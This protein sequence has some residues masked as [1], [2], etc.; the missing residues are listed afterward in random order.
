MHE[1]AQH[2]S[3][4][5]EHKEELQDTAGKPQES[6]EETPKAST[7]QDSSGSSSEDRDGD[8]DFQDFL[9]P[10]AAVGS[11]NRRRSSGHLNFVDLVSA[12][13]GS[14]LAGLEAKQRDN[15]TVYSRSTGT[16]S[17]RWRKCLEM[18]SNK[19]AK[20]PVSKAPTLKDLKDESETV[21]LKR[22][23]DGR[24]T[25]QELGPCVPPTGLEFEHFPGADGRPR[26]SFCSSFESGNLAVAQCEGPDLYTLLVD[27]DANTDGYTQWFYFAVQGGSCGLKVTFRLVNMAKS[28]SLFGEK[29]MRPVVWSE[30]SG[31]GWERGCADVSYSKSAEA[32]A[33]QPLMS[34]QKQ[35]YTL[36]FSYTFEHD[37]D[38]VFFAYHY[39]YTYSHLCDFIDALEAHPYAG[40]L[41]SRRVLCR[42]IGDLPCEVLDVDCDTP[43]APTSDK[44]IAVITARIHPGESNASWMMHG[45]MSFL[46]SPAAEAKALRQAF[47]W[48]IVPMLNPDGVVRGCYR[49]GLA[50]TDLN[51]V[52]AKPSKILHPEIYHLKETIKRAGRTVELYI[53]F[54]GHSK[55]E[56]IFFYGGKA[57]DRDRNADI[58]LL[59]RLCC[60]GSSDFKWRKCA[61]NLNESKM[62]TARLVGFRE[63]GIQRV[64]TVEASFAGSG[65]AV[66]E[67]EAEASASEASEASDAVGEQEGQEE[68]SAL[69]EHQE[70]IKEAATVLLQQ[71]AT[72]ERRESV[73]GGTAIRK[74]TRSDLAQVQQS[75]RRRSLRQMTSRSGSEEDLKSPKE[76]SPANPRPSHLRQPSCPVSPN[77]PTS[78]RMSGASSP[79]AA[80]SASAELTAKSKEKVKQN[81]RRASEM[82]GENPESI[83]NE[84]NPKRLELAGP[85]IGRAICA[86]WQ[87]EVPAAN[88]QP[89]DGFLDGTESKQWPHLHYHRLTAEAAQRELSKLLSGRVGH[90]KDGEDEDGSDSNPSADEKPVLE[91][92]KLQR[93][94]ARK[95]KRQKTFK[96]VAES[97]PEEEIKYRVVVAFGKAVKIPSKGGG[98]AQKGSKIG[99]A[100]E[101]LIKQNGERRASMNDMSRHQVEHLPH[102]GDANRV[103]SESPQDSNDSAA[104]SPCSSKPSPNLLPPT[105]PGSPNPSAMSRHWTRTSVSSIVPPSSNEHSDEEPFDEPPDCPWPV[106]KDKS[107]QLHVID[108][109]VCGSPSSR[110]ASPT[111]NSVAGEGSPIEDSSPVCDE[112]MCPAPTDGTDP[113]SSP[114][115]TKSRKRPGSAVQ[116]G[117]RPIVYSPGVPP[118]AGSNAG[119]STIQIELPVSMAVEAPDKRPVTHQVRTVAKASVGAR[120]PDVAETK[121]SHVTLPDIPGR[122]SDAE[123]PPVQSFKDWLEREVGTEAHRGQSPPKLA[124]PRTPAAVKVTRILSGPASSERTDPDPQ[125]DHQEKGAG[126]AEETHVN[127]V[128]DEVDKKSK[129]LSKVSVHFKTSQPS[130]PTVPPSRAT[131]AKVTPH[132]RRVGRSTL[133]QGQVQETLQLRPDGEQTASDAA[134]LS[135]RAIFKDDSSASSPA[136]RPHSAERWKVTRAFPTGS[137]ERK[138]SEAKVALLELCGSS[139]RASGTVEDPAS[140]AWDFKQPWHLHAQRHGVHDRQR[141]VSPLVESRYYSAD[142]AARSCASRLRKGGWPDLNIE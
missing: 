142:P 62:S 80:Q 116:E 134:P 72:H 96:F 105:L 33:K 5:L 24:P 115:R 20:R 103:R 6:P 8:N 25:C 117:T 76:A 50:G 40:S 44:G 141:A 58:R 31:R 100:M 61:F 125:K 55:K 102:G 104:P 41:F 88:Q 22:P 77:G 28:G 127:I 108:L 54:H 13:I 75:V 91:L 45:F 123:R 49:C 35:W 81:K 27:V 52:Y 36:S 90:E 86:V 48:L 137:P 89:L 3:T 70:Q 99:D 46:L 51:R 84:F 10:S 9:P 7:F 122:S 1:R 18:L 128:N 78:P 23:C 19:Y 112:S 16:E 17:S 97:E 82:R 79:K 47:K 2:S 124:R 107:A 43:D 109:Q 113:S 106:K 32:P 56:G 15:A 59:P 136:A 26:L 65:Q 130:Q 67:L 68:K 101:K 60:L 66:L 12:G 119:G 37:D 53:D 57:E 11:G 38:T 30:K 120:T 21:V 93:R 129:V 4:V 133:P 92:R 118:V 95:S 132:A 69:E 42:T 98:S 94:L 110:A 87:L 73:A 85:T 63:L 135:Q 64:Y 74:G 14:Y 114:L 131:A 111:A 126:A 140:S 83:S 138:C 139:I 39:P 121:L 34:G 71:F 29:G